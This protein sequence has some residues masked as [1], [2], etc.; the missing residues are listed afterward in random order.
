[1]ASS[2]R[3]SS[4]RREG[5]GAASGLE[6]SIDPPHGDAYV[7]TARVSIRAPGL[8][9]HTIATFSDGPWDL[10]L[11]FGQ[12]AADWRGW[13]GERHWRAL[14]GELEVQASHL[15]ARVLIA[16]T[17]RRPDMTFAND[18]WEARIVLTLE[19]GEQLD[20][21]ARDLASALASD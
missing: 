13:E 6:W 17:V 11:F 3:I 18:A 9:A 21:V 8:E 19:P 4:A 16:V 12:L 1:V 2:F 5:R 7:R 15:G 20:R 14:E 10:A